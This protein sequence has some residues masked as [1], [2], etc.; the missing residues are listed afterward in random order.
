[1][2][3]V[4]KSLGLVVCLFTLLTASAQERD[5]GSDPATCQRNLSL[6]QSDYQ[7]NNYTSAIEHW[8]KVWKDCPLSSANLT[9]HGANMYKYFIDREL[10]QDNKNALID[11]LMM[12][13]EKGITLR[14]T[15]AANYQ[16]YMMQD[17]L[18]YA[19]TPENQPKI[20][21]MLEQAMDTQKE[22][23]SA[24]TYVSYWKILMS[25]NIAGKISDEVLL[26][27]Y[28]KLNDLLSDAIRKT[29]NEELAR[30]RDLI[31]ETFVNSS[32]AGCE[33]L[34]KIYSAKYDDNKEDA[35]FLRKLTRLLSRKD[36]T[37]SKLFEQ[38]SEHMYALN[39]TAD[40]A[41]NMAR[42]FLRRENYEKAVE[43]F[44]NAI[45]RETDPFEKAR[46]NHQ[47]GTIMLSQYKKHNDAKKYAVEASKL[48]PDW[49]QP[50]ILLAN[51]YASGS[52]CGEDDFEQRYIYWVVV[53]KLQRAKSV[54]PE[55]ANIVDPLIRQ[56]SQHF[57]KKED[58]F[59]RDVLEGATVTVGCWINES[60]RVRYPN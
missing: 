32:A 51:T 44:E 29:T 10:N 52:K 53:D 11:T 14:P 13:W 58:G 22:K 42:L 36:C 59:F 23:T 12:V 60:T 31:D 49:G 34:I 30:A 3:N 21:K 48:R 55:V 50:Y 15:A 43:Y 45:S 46:Y 25:E 8:R 38:A 39:P 9:V 47:L 54:D 33:N 6:Y 28:T 4:V 5:F 56:F 37:D 16:T 7:L 24:L 17:M 20:M 2:K 26:D 1:M 41:Y 57:P 35:E 27:N 40:A 19:D 18:K